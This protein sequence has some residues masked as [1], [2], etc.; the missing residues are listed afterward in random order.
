MFGYEYLRRKPA[1]IR[2]DDRGFRLVYKHFM[3]SVYAACFNDPF[4][5]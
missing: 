1:V 4:T 5:I 2:Y 3:W